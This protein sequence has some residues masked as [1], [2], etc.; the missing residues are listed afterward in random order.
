MSNKEQRLIL[1]LIQDTQEGKLEWKESSIEPSS[2]SG[3]ER[4]I[5]S[6]YLVKVNDK[7]MRIYKYDYRDYTDYD[8]YVL[9]QAFKLEFA[10]HNWTKSLYS[11]PNY[12]QL[13]DLYS[14]VQRQVTG[15]EGFLDEYLDGFE[16]PK[17]EED[18]LLL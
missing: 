2:L 11:F 17:E 15:V 14:E 1:K 12:T 16:P 8:E 4:L 3:T 13:E 10:N 18:E 6:P 5:N 9:N 7:N